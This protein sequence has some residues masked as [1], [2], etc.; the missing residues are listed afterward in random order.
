MAGLES[1]LAVTDA[2]AALFAAQD[3][4]AQS[5]QNQ[6]LG[7]VSL[8]KALGG[9]WL[10]TFRTEDPPPEEAREQSAITSAF[11]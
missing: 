2:E 11:R 5:R 6:I 3:E 4:L 7:F 10:N 9:G 8:Y 1:Y